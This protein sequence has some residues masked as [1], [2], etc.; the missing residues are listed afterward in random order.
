MTKE[1][2]W[3]SLLTEKSWELL[4][5]FRRTHDFILIGGWAVYLLTKQHKSKD[6]DLI[7]EIK[8]LD[9]LKSEYKENLRKND[10]LKKYEIKEGEI[11]I[12]IYLEYYS[13][14]VIPA[15]DLKNY[16]VSI[17][18]FKIARPEILLI[19]KQAAYQSRKNSVK[20]EKDKIDI[21]SLAFFTDIDF[22]FYHSVLNKYLLNNY[23]L[24]LKY[25][26]KSFK[27]YDSLGLNARNFKLQ[28]NKILKK[29]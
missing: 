28:K 17:E 27:D 19:L 26:I 23:Y 11:D 1:K 18:G 21:A 20:G 16:I 15:E 22:K 24:E 12:D 14:F 3:N 2:F 9:A 10:S 29:I 25:L 7:I 8:D 13:R 4:Q 6:I 5:K